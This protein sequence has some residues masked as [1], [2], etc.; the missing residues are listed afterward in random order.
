MEILQGAEGLGPL[1][2]AEQNYRKE[3]LLLHNERLACQ[4]AVS[5]DL[6]VRVPDDSKLPHLTYT[7]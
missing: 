6:V 7:G 3:G 2:A 1:T 4:A 5:K